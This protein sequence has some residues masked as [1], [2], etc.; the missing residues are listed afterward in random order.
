MGIM[1]NLIELLYNNKAEKSNSIDLDSYA[2]GLTDMYIA[3]ESQPLNKWI[4]VEDVLPDK[5]HQMVDVVLNNGD[6][7]IDVNYDST[8]DE[9]IRWYKYENI[10]QCED[11]LVVFMVSYWIPT[12]QPPKQINK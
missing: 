7:V 11:I 4:S 12:V 5:Q 1:K 10:G 6:R 9:G 8:L 3:L 2:N